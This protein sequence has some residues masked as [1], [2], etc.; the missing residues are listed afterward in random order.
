MV[1]D[2]PSSLVPDP[3]KFTLER[4]MVTPPQA[5]TA[6]A[7]PP[8][9]K[10]PRFSILQ[11]NVLITQIDVVPQYY[12]CPEYAQ[13]WDYRGPNLV[14]EM[15]GY[16]PDI[17]CMQEVDKF[18]HF[19][20]SFAQDGYA[21]IYQP[22]PYK[23]LD[24]LAFFYKKDKFK[25]IKTHVINYNKIHMPTKDPSAYFL[26][27]RFGFINR[28]K[29]KYETNNI[30]LVCEMETIEPTPRRLFVATTHI[31]WNPKMP[32]LKVLQSY[33][34]L[35]ELEKILQVGEKGKTMPPLVITGD[36]NAMP[37]SGMYQLYATRKLPH[38]HADIQ[39]LVLKDLSHNIPISSAYSAF[40]EPLTNITKGFVGTLDYI[41]Y[42]NTQLALHKVLSPI[43]PDT[44]MPNL[45]FSSDHAALMCELDF[46][47]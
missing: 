32:E 5:G 7:N 11:Y 31:Y 9:P 30:A 16:N 21:G 13:N 42:A 6:V 17:I 18:E 47:D 19:N 20:S 3:S 23:H 15:R 25:L 8:V 34:L 33:T 41:W 29:S 10:G 26:E 43:P 28:G 2:T 40:G 38:T 37:S 27:N 35:K 22:R 36:F 39:S 46:L 44:Y 45:Q 12:Y 4:L 14:R 1:D 24:G